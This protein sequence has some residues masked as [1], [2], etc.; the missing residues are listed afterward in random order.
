MNL[1]RDILLGV[2]LLATGPI[3]GY[4]SADS[5]RFSS[6]AAGYIVRAESMFS[7]G[8]YAGVIDQLRFLSTSGVQLSAE[9][10]ER[11]SYMLAKS[12]FE[13]GNEECLDLLIEFT[14]L[15]PASCLCAEA[16]L[17]IG[18]YYFYKSEWPDAYEA[19]KLVDFDRLNRDNKVLYC[20]REMLSMIKT[21]HYEE[22]HPLLNELKGEKEYADAYHFY[23]GYLDYIA[24]DF[25]TAFKE[26]EKVTPSVKGLEAGYYMTQILYSRGE[27]NRVIKS[28][29]SLLR[30]MPVK[31]LVG[32]TERVIGMSYFKLGEYDVAKGELSNYFDLLADGDP[33]PE[34]QYAMGVICYREGDH[35]EAE[36]YLEPLSERR[37]EIG[38]GACFTLGQ[39]YVERGDASQGAL[40]FD[41][42]I[43]IAADK[44]LTEMAMYNYVTTL[45]RGG[46]VP[47]ASSAKMLE[48]FVKRYPDSR[49]AADVESYLAIAY[50][51]D[52]N[53]KEALRCINSIANPD[54]A[55]LSIKQKVLYE[56]GVESMTN[57][58]AQQA[59]KYL[60][61]GLKIQ[62]G[63]AAMRAQA[64]LWLGDALY[65]L[66][67]YS[68]ALKSYQA[69]ANSKTN[70]NR[71]LGYYDLGYCQYK[72]G[73]YA[74]AA[75]SFGLALN[76][77]TGLDSRQLE[78]AKL[79]RA[80]C[81]YYQG[82]YKEASKLYNES[83]S[84][85]ETDA[86]Y[87]IYRRAMMAGMSG[88]NA[89]KLRDLALLEREY[90]ESRWLSA[91]LL[92]QARTYEHLGQTANAA[93]AYKRRLAITTDVDI[94][95]LVKVAATMDA[96]SRWSD[97][98]EVVDKIERAGGL[99]PEEMSEISM[100]KA[101]ALAG[102]GQHK[103]ARELYEEL[104]QTPSSLAGAKG[105]VM[106]AEMM[107]KSG[108][109]AAAR[110]RMEQFADE[111]TPH[112]Y[113]LARGYIVLAEAIH[114]QGNNSL[115]KQY[116]EALQENYPA[117]DDDINTMINSRLKKCK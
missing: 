76:A 14:R 17:A 71:A 58:G 70:Q 52:R 92:E 66:G 24:G 55:T 40:M 111:G 93:D 11:C 80:D 81:L 13:R 5:H 51:N 29:E 60:Q 114:A 34:A 108:D 102:T 68:D 18:D 113:W 28:G 4:E 116:L 109:Y 98:L 91:A 1:H 15:Y 77:K 42:A 25:N 43:D 104:S 72:L 85:N 73:K 89:G 61:D 67:K 100:Y 54:S 105:A 6:D 41:R 7:G 46:K 90:P 30:K 2:A 103:A 32:E 59:V 38:Q 10:Q 37:D 79:R 22:A 83:A 53:Y 27:Y 3:Y 87:A 57:G 8:N 31:E 44:Q 63:D 9:E 47:F 94:D 106:A 50:Y 107:I 88:D 101:D 19:Y 97:L 84:E 26:F 110:K 69:F 12:Y 35:A 65:S 82:S 75:K 20:Y 96:A 64:S 62:G 117:T 99:E 74:E 23:K 49:Y 86:D 39:I 16:K 95:E 48:Q 112:E 33:D 45:T 56:L 78:D 115:A 36:E 21:G